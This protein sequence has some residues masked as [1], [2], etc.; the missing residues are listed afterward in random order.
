M[1]SLKNKA[2]TLLEIILTVSI[3]VLSASILSPI[4]LSAKNRDDLSTKTDILVS[5]LRR[6]QILSI[7]G[8]EDSS[9][10]V[11]ILEDS[12]VVFKGDS[13]LT[14][15]TSQDDVI[16]VNKNILT[17]GLD[18][19]VFTKIFGETSNIGDITLK[20]KNKE[21]IISINRKGMIDY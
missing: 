6:A 9:W 18:E 8:Q 1:F 13:Y 12:L 17:E 11:K 5:S 15:D 4:Y 14:R 16:A 7:S 21:I 2:F 20:T 3:F 19:I 10:G